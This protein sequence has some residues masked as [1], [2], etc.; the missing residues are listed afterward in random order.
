M[1][2]MLLKKAQKE[3]E[4]ALK[5]STISAP[6]EFDF[7]AYKEKELKKGE[8][9]QKMG[10]KYYNLVAF[11]ALPIYALISFFVYR[12][13][14][15]YGEHLVINAY[16]QG[17]LLISILFAFIISLVTHP[18]VY[19]GMFMLSIVYYLYVYG[20]LYQL[21]FWDNMLKLLKFFGIM[22]GAMLF[23]F[24]VGIVVGFVRSR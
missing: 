4:A 1:E 15:N 24:L 19:Y 22:F 14:Y 12:K 17:F 11:L 23:L 5:D 2:P 10:L 9:Q 20:K 21:P 6:A 13:P 3:H 18:L 16:M 7:E 8:A